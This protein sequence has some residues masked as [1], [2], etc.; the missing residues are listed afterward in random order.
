MKL[1]ELKRKSLFRIIEDK[2][3]PPGSQPT[4]KGDVYFFD[5]MDGMYSYCEDKNGSPVHVMALT[6]VEPVD[7]WDPLE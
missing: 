4:E 1:Y 3:N 5:H 6:E 2:G 7:E